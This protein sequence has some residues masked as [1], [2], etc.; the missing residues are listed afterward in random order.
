MI[1]RRPGVGIRI[2]HPAV[3]GQH[4]RITVDGDGCT[5]TDLGS[6]NGTTV[7]GA[8]IDRATRLE[9]GDQIVL[10]QV[11]FAF[12]VDSQPSRAEASPPPRES[13][14][15]ELTMQQRIEVMPAAAVDDEE[16]A[17]IE[18]APADVRFP[19]AATG[20]DAGVRRITRRRIEIRGAEE[21]ARHA[22]GAA[23]E[24]AR[25]FAAP[26]NR[27][28]RVPTII[29]MEAV[30]CGA[31]ALAMI[32]ARHDRWIPLEQLRVQCG[33][34]R[35]GSKASN[36]LK[37][38]RRLGMTAKG[39][40]YES[41]E[42][43]YELDAPAI[44][45]WNFNHFVVLEGFARGKAW[46]ND[47]AQGPR[48]VPLDEL[49]T[50]FSGIVLTFE[51]GP[52]FG[53]GGQKPG[54]TAA[55]RRRLSGSE[56]AL[57]FIIV[58]GLFLVVPGLVV[59]TFTRIFVD[60]ILVA[61]RYGLLRSLLL[62]MG[63]TALLIMALTCFQHLLPAAARDQGGAEHLGGVLPPRPA[64]ARELLRPALRR[65]D[66]VAGDDQRQGGA[67]ALRPARDH[68]A[69]LRAGGVLRRPDALLRRLH[70]AGGHRPLVAQH[71]GDV[72]GVEAPHRRQSPA[73]ARGGKAHRHGD[74]RSRQYRD[75]EGH[76][77]RER[78][79]RP[80]GRL[81][82][83]VVAGRAGAR[84]GRPAGRSGARSGADDDHRLGAPAGQRQGDERRDEHRHA[85]R[86]SDPDEQL[87]PAAQHPGV[88]RVAPA[89][90][91]RRHGAARRRAQPR[92]R[93]PVRRR[94][95]RRSV[96]RT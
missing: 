51:P 95:R 91:A 18:A 71:R 42:K 36:L 30:E 55:L 61:S 63:I 39:F 19:G 1:G 32:L 3:S 52:E 14:P 81:S 34:S 82:G 11:V 20:S 79:L 7:N 49:D 22:E 86:L 85:D 15:R 69:R 24:S 53:P 35:D 33:V 80:V 92:A 44:L 47:P 74:E 23:G 28:H 66:R 83:Q 62:G 4:A 12:E 57:A 13:A 72:P 21:Q 17:Q 90:A 38:A 58:C 65:R 64:L 75:L 96:R 9:P 5:I 89:G 2:P 59:P 27:R 26:P 6:S 25:E 70:D 37:G 8:R 93:P 41:I 43:L 29:Q 87:R 76:R 10:G 78:V 88:V 60:E 94:R 84:A 68:R 73:A 31:A 16:L 56:S 77:R 67:A 50:A 48:A 45:F 54:M 40:K 46:I